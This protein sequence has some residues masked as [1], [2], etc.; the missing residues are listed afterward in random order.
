MGEEK[1]TINVGMVG[2]KMMGRAHSHAYRDVPFY[3]DNL[4]TPRL[5]TIV[6]RD[7]S[8]VGPAAEKMGWARHATDWRSLINRSDIDLPDR[9]AALESDFDAG[10][11]GSC[12]L[13]H[14]STPD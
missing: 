4:V 9:Y 3:F 8:R 6:G 5:D 10:V 1:K 12:A 11:Y 7:S 2:Y 13:V 14:L